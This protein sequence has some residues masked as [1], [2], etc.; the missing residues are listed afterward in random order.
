MSAPA[1]P[2]AALE[3]TAAD[4]VA[5]LRLKFAETKAF[6]EHMGEYEKVFLDNGIDGA[7]MS[8]IDQDALDDAGVKR[9][10]HKNQI[11]TKWKLD[12]GGG[13]T[14]AG[15]RAARGSAAHGGSSSGCRIYS[16]RSTA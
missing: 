5:W 3:C 4:V 12:F 14:G 1:S 2:G 7:T 9:P 15:A 13:G 11:L 6:M 10:L 16:V 8:G